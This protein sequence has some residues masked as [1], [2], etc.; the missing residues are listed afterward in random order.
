MALREIMALFRGLLPDG[1]EGLFYPVTKID[2][3]EGLQEEI[4]A[5]KPIYFEATI[6]TSWTGTVAPYSQTITVAGILS[7]DKPVM[8][9]RV[10]DT[11]ATAKDQ[12]EAFGKLHK[13]KTSAGRITVTAF[14]KTTVPIPITLEVKR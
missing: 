5:R 11:A 1:D 3:V 2:C 13:I 12:L 4:D 10:S 7:T 6:G 9:D 8:Y 14:E